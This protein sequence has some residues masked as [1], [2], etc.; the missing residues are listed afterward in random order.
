MNTITHDHHHYSII[1]FSSW[2][3]CTG[4]STLESCLCPTFSQI[5]FIFYFQLCIL[6]LNLFSFFI[7]FDHSPIWVPIAL[8]FVQS[9]MEEKF[10]NSTFATI[11]AIQPVAPTTCFNKLMALYCNTAFQPC[12][13]LFIPELNTKGKERKDE[14]WIFLFLFNLLLLL[15]IKL[16]YNIIV[17]IPAPACKSVCRYVNDECHLFC[18]SPPTT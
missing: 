16:T 1:P 17:P 15:L 7:T 9:F 10:K 6:L 4:M 3:H 5:L 2:C 13:E 8:P 14:I 11:I 12:Q 18:K